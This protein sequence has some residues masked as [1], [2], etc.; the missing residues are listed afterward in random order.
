MRAWN[1]TRVHAAHVLHVSQ[2]IVLSVLPQ[3]RGRVFVDHYAALLRQ[4]GEADALRYMQ[5]VGS[6]YARDIPEAHAAIRKARGM[7]DFQNIA[8]K[9]FR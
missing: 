8:E 7:E 1:V 5:H 4:Y 9:W 6:M 2:R 3:E